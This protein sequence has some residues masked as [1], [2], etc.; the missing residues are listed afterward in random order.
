MIGR[1]DS[2]SILALVKVNGTLCL[3]YFLTSSINELKMSVLG[4]GIWIWKCITE[5]RDYLDTGTPGYYT[6][7]LLFTQHIYTT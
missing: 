7:F 1:K 5:T 2:I 4:F 6:L 3:Q